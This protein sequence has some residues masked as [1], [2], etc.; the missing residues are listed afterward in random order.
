MEGGFSR[1]FLP[2]GWGRVFS[3]FCEDLLIFSCYVVCVCLWCLF[4]F[5][6][7]LECMFVCTIVSHPH[8]CVSCRLWQYDYNFWNIGNSLI[9]LES[10]IDMNHMGNL[11]LDSI[12][13][14]FLNFIGIALL[15]ILKQVLFY[16]THYGS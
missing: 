7:V 15:L 3:I 5:F 11:L 2:R 14:M 13:A 10:E 6:L 1:V 16:F 9:C 12:K 8:K 4:N